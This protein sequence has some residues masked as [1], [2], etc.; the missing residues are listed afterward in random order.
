VTKSEA[1]GKILYAGFVPVIVADDLPVM[2]CLEQMVP[3][4][5]EAVEISIRHPQALSL[6]GQAKSRFPQMAIGAAGLVEDGRLRD[7]LNASGTPL[8]SIAQCV[9][10][11]ADF[12]VSMLPFGEGTYQRYRDSHVIVPGVSTAGE[13]YQALDLGANLLNFV[14]A[15][16]LGGHEFFRA[17]EAT[18]Y[19]T[20]PYFVATPMKCHHAGGYVAA[21][22]LAIEAGFNL[23]LGPDYRPMQ[24]AFDEEL[25]RERLEPFVHNIA[26]ARQHYQEHIPFASRDAEAISK[27]SGRL[28]NL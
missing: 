5:L 24:R 23:I 16:L 27:A 11:G 10:A 7:F 22:A 17:L 8:P 14:N 18:T 2:G 3:Y 28:L 12:L 20:F 21:G 1:L 13:G 15:H 6:I 4:G 9:D 25:V 26:R 19:Q